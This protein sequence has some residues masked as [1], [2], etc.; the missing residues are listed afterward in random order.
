[1][2]EKE[3]DAKELVEMGVGLAARAGW[4]GSARGAG[5]GDE[6]VITLR[7][8]RRAIEVGEREQRRRPERSATDGVETHP[9]DGRPAEVR[10]VQCRLRAREPA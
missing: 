2:S 4:K 8:Q 5:A 6:Y 1:M 9:L 10:R 7:V 3:A